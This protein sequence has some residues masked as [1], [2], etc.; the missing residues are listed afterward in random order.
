MIE[1]NSN[2]KVSAISYYDESINERIIKVIV[3]S[4]CQSDYGKF[5]F[6]LDSSFTMRYI[7][8]KIIKKLIPQI[9]HKLSYKDEEKFYIINFANDAFFNEMTKK[10]FATNEKKI[11]SIGSTYMEYVPD[12][13]LEILNKIE[14]NS[15][16]N[17][18]IFSDCKLR[19]V[20]ETK[21]NVEKIN[22]FIK[23]KNIR[24]NCQ[25]VIFENSDKEDEPE[26]S[27]LYS[28]LS[29]NNIKNI[30]PIIIKLENEKEFSD[31]EI[32]NYSLLISEKFN[33]GVCGWKIVSK[34]KKLRY[35]PF[36]DEFYDSI[37]LTNKNSICYYHER[38]ASEIHLENVNDSSVKNEIVDKGNLNEE[39]KSE[40]YTP[41][42]YYKVS[43]S[44][45]ENVQKNPEKGKKENEKIL[46]KFGDN[47]LIKDIN[48]KIG[49][50]KDIK[51][52]NLYINTQI[53]VNK[54]YIE[55]I[56][57]GRT[58]I[59]NNLN[60]I[61]LID[62]SENMKDYLIYFID[63]ILIQVFEKMNI[64]NRIPTIINGMCKNLTIKIKNIYPKIEEMKEENLFMDSFKLL[65]DRIQHNK[66]KI[67]LIIVIFSKLI[68]NINNTEIY[69]SLSQFEK[70][71]FK[72]C[73]NVI[74][75]SSSDIIDTNSQ[76]EENKILYGIIKQIS[77]KEIDK[78]EDFNPLI[79]DRNEIKEKGEKV[80]DDIYSEF[81]KFFNKKV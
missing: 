45:I 75:L 42:F 66:D 16:I 27:V 2:N 22:N 21:T 10:E 54:S 76:L 37:I 4:N 60:I 18:L 14:L 79:V 43:Q 23:E 71:Q 36:G 7:L 40:F 68:K 69:E 35:L 28:F 77:S 51:E 15:I 47:R 46:E 55:S 8:E 19:D 12:K 26:F 17:L 3:D 53:G 52:L 70:S 49:E 56:A 39:N 29:L 78:L 41:F 5:I 20:E 74:K 50:I 67:N 59:P 61:I 24:V 63:N 65:I 38:N 6:I 80:I 58:I 33:I 30:E 9:L 57:Q 72:I 73:S 31:K 81:M 44:M 13:I 62:Y 32:I 11:E 1:S 25:F 48:E 64:K 34:Q